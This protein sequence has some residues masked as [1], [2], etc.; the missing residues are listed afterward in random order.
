MASYK[1]KVLCLKEK[2]D[3]LR[4]VD[5][6]TAQERADIAKEL[7]LP[8]STLNSAIAKCADIERNAMLFGPKAN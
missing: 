3:V 1:R 6:Q 7:E 8:P 4:A 2:L 5:A